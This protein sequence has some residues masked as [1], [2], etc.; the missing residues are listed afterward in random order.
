MASAVSIQFREMLLS[1]LFMADVFT[2]PA[3]LYVALTSNVA[4][5]NQSGNTLRE[6]IAGAYSRGAIDLD[7]LS[8]ATT[9]FGDVANVV[10]IDFP[11][12]TTGEDWGYLSGWALVSDATAGS[13]YAV[14]S[15]VLATQYTSDQPFLSIKPGGIVVGLTD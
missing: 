10:D 4:L 13:T 7:S 6:P 1:S 11:P 3:Q 14:G 8:W 5:I 15:L 12:P 9:G 2:A